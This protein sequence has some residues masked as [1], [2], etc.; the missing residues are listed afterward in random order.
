MRRHSA[1]LPPIGTS[2]ALGVGSMGAFD[3][4]ET[5][6]HT[7]RSRENRFLIAQQRVS[8]TPIRKDQKEETDAQDR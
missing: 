2:V 7:T 8:G 4:S 6:G 3:T 1:A 5:G